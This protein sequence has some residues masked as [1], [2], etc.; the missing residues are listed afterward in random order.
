[1]SIEDYRRLPP[2]T[3]GLRGA[4]EA[5]RRKYNIEEAGFE[6]ADF[7]GF[8]TSPPAVRSNGREA[9]SGRRPRRR[10]PAL[11][12]PSGGEPPLLPRVA[13]MPAR[14]YTHQV[15]TLGGIA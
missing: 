13:R 15:P 6:D 8:G 11:P 1:L 7:E 9:V 10:F 4:I 12:R 14:C 2:S 5:F 3:G